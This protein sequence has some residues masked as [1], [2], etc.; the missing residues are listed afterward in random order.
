MAQ[1]DLKHMPKPV[2]GIDIVDFAGS[3]NSAKTLS[4]LAGTW[5]VYRSEK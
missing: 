3:C 5:Q 1:D 2:E 4:V